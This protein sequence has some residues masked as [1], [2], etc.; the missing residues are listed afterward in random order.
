MT[1]TTN[2][3][4]QYGEKP[5]SQRPATNTFEAILTIASGAALAGVGIW[6]RSW[7][8]AALAGGGGYLV[9]CGI[10]DFRRP[11]QGRVR[12]G[13][14]IA[15]ES[16]EVYDFVADPQNWNRFLHVLRLE[17]HGDGRLRLQ[18]GKPAGIDFESSVEITDQKPG[19][20]IAWASAEEYMLEHRGVIRFDKAPGNRGTELKVALEFKAPAGP[21][22]RALA[23]FVGW[24]PE[25]L[26]RESLRHVKQLLEAGEI[27][28]TVGQPVG[29]RGLKGAAMRVML[30]ERPSE[31]AVE[32]TRLAGD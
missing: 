5:F 9:Y 20:Y 18:I 24:D 23:S 21:V 11:Y 28:T 31:D 14:T 13:F 2:L 27:P 1:I 25:Q 15:K 6:R 29:E 17:P 8:G 3:A 32:Q 19:E 22:A 10:Q 30:R 16:R 26:V 7:L 12:V 4:P